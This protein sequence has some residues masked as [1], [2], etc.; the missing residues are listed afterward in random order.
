M[1]RRRLLDPGFW[2]DPRVAKLTFLERLV[3]LGCVSMAD[4]EGRLLASPRLLRAQIFPYDQEISD[5][6][7]KG[8]R[9]RI[10]QTNP[11][12]VLYEVDGTEYMAFTKWERYQK[13]PHKKS[14]IFPAPSRITNVPEEGKESV[15]QMSQQ[16]RLGKDRLGKASSRIGDVKHNDQQESSERQKT[17]AAYVKLYTAAPP[18]VDVPYHLYPSEAMQDKIEEYADIWGDDV[19]QDAIREAVNSGKPQL[20][21]KYIESIIFRWKNEGR[22]K[23]RISKEEYERIEAQKR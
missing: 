19:V 5:E 1:P 8:V 14:S 4:D 21:P 22:V 13:P 10:V 11:N 3:F 23:P 9:D 15:S 20:P 17:I 6:E 7:I 2:S 18:G 12:V 16:V